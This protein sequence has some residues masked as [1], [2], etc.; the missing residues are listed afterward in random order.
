MPDRASGYV[1]DVGYTTRYHPA[2]NPLRTRLAF[3]RAGREP[4]RIRTACELGFGQGVSLAVHAAASPIAWWGNDLLPQHVAFARSLVDASGSRAVLAEAS[5]EEFDRRT[6]LPAFDFIGLHGVLSWIS[7]ENRDC[8]IDFVRHHLAP[9]GVVYTGCN[10]LPGWADML[11]LR[12][13]MA[14]FATRAAAGPTVGRIESAIDFAARL[15]ETH[16]LHAR[17]SPALAQRLDRLRGAD[18]RYLAHEYFNRDWQPLPFTELAALFEKAGLHHACSAHLPDHLDELNLTSEHRRLLADLPDAGLRETVRDFITNAQFRRDYWSREAAPLDAREGLAAWADQR[19]ALVTA[20][21]SIPD[22]V[23]GP[24]GEV[25][26]SGAPTRAVVA[27]LSERGPQTLAQLARR[28][29][30]HDPD[31]ARLL[32][33]VFPLIATEHVTA[34]LEDSETAGQ[35]PRTAAL[36]DA[37]CAGLVAGAD[38]AVLASPV[39]GAGHPV[40]PLEQAFLSARTA[41]GDA[42]QAWADDAAERLGRPAADLLAAAVR[43]AHTRLPLLQAL[44]VV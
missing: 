27:A 16:P 17:T 1:T 28:V 10:A 5:F 23:T 44:Q 25:R 33:A 37:I 24:L 8:I 42:P 21:E 14:E 2:L 30:P 9:G 19:V 3:L 41:R 20:P 29:S 4:P 18:P 15:F 38:V 6:D 31:V 26:L 13:V 43:F 11:P 7:A 40:S 32:D 12:H 36:N 35:R 22:R 39:T 34:A